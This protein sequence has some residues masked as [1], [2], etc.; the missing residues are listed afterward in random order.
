MKAA[1]PLGYSIFL[2]NP[3]QGFSF[4]RHVTHKVEVFHVLEVH[5]GGYVFLCDY[6]DWLRFYKRDEFSRWFDGEPNPAIERY[7]FYPQPGDVISID[8]LNVV[9]TVV[10]CTIEEFAT[11]STDMVDRLHDQNPRDRIPAHFTRQYAQGRLRTLRAPGATG[12]QV[13]L[14]AGGFEA[15]P[16]HA[17]SV[18]GGQ[19]LVLEDRFLTAARCFV[20]PGET[21]AFEDTDGDAVALYVFEGTGSLEIVAPDESSSPP[22]RCLSQRETRSSFRQACAFAWRP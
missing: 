3:G 4:Q 9:H 18:P 11:T 13:L 2:Q 17:S 8:R 6:A 16:L 7:R 10:G 20:G 19:R 5:P 15:R 12:R 22:P 21:S 14:T 1:H